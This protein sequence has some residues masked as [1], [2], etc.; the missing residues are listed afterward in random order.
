[1]KSA[2]VTLEVRTPDGRY[3]RAEYTR[4]GKPKKPDGTF[5][6]RYV[7]SGNRKRQRLNTTDPNEAALL[8]HKREAQLAA[9]AHGVSLALASPINPATKDSATIE[10]AATMYLE[11]SKTKSYKTLRAYS[12][13]VNLFLDFCATNA[14]TKLPVDR[15]TMLMFKAWLM[16]REESTDQFVRNNFL[17]VATFLNDRGYHV[18]L[19]RKDWPKVSR[20]PDEKYEVYTEQEIAFM[21][22]V[23]DADEADLILFF[24]G[25]G[26]RLLEVSH[27]QYS[28]IDWENSM[29]RVA[30]KP[31]WN[32]RTKDREAKW[33]EVS[34]SLLNTLKL[35]MVRESAATGDLIFPARSG[36]PDRHLDRR[37]SVIIRKAVKAGHKIKRPCKPCHAFRVLFACRRAEAGVPI[38]QIRTWLRHS[39]IQTTQIYLRSMRRGSLKLRAKIDAADDFGASATAVAAD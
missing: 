23:A 18:P 15:D 26:F 30:D 27:A 8:V 14:V 24:V 10:D 39:D 37:V 6:L 35:R 34:K 17:R 1:M 2:K 25:T 19:Q 33:I 9:A 21:L 16:G 4:S 38:E 3:H 36:G 20:D 12:R 28:D 22:A 32:F 31:Q 29:I 13:A 5:Y 7:E 11:L